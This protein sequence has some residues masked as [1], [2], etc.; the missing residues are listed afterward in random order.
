MTHW[1]WTLCS[2]DNVGIGSDPGG[3]YETCGDFIFYLPTG[4]DDCGV[5]NPPPNQPPNNPPPNQPP[6]QQPVNFPNETN[7]L[8]NGLPTNPWGVW[9]AIVPTAQCGDITCLTIGQGALGNV[10]LS[11]VS[12]F[13]IP[14]PLLF[15]VGVIWWALN[16]QHTPVHGLWTHGNWCGT[17]GS[18]LPTDQ[19]DYN[20][21]VHDYCYTMNNFT[22]GD[23]RNSGLSAAQSA[24]L[25][26]CNQQLCDSENR[27]GG[28][29]AW[30]ISHFFQ[31]YP[32]SGTACH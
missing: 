12:P 31:W 18:G 15:Q 23:N 25:Q 32:Y 26:G 14:G 3:S 13:N 11:G 8:P 30:Q 2:P 28:S 16:G 5:V 19:T 10:A 24:A 20:C 29:T 17:G 21:M 1:A 9:G 6:S 7:G 22:A 27:V 4:C